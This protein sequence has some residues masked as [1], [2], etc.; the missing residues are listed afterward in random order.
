[1]STYYED[2]RGVKDLDLPWKTLA[3]TNILIVGAT[4]LI[5]R[6]LVDVLMQL[7]H[8]NFHLYAGARD[9]VYAQNCFAEYK[10][11]AAF[12]I[13]S[14]DVVMPMPFDMDFHYII[15]AASYAAPSAFKNDPVGVITAN[16]GGVDHLFSYGIQH[17]L[18]KLLYVSS[19]E[20]Y[21]EGNGTPF[22]EEDS[23]AFDWFSLRACYPLAK[24]TAETLC[25]SYASQYQIETSIVRPCHI[26][27]PFF[28]PKDDRAYAQFIRNVVA[29]ENIVLKSPGLQQRS[30]CY[31]VDCAFAI[32]HVL[33]K[34]E[35]GNAYNIADS[36]ANVSIR[37]FAGMIASKDGLEVVFELP[38]QT[39]E[40]PIIS[41]AF[42]ATEKIKDLGW[43]PQWSLEEGISHTLNTLV[44]T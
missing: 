12:T 27:G 1:M 25:V 5:G 30:W 11:E 38:E 29:G 39:R 28:T 18:R 32:L 43:H 44:E 33:L 17:H 8:R 26:Y 13:L 15:H 35:N 4:G 40:N 14:Y 24:R 34:G 23:G 37:E 36:Q 16:I 10:D 21:G 42:F 31:V 3:E 20:V 19:G 2:I 6:A 22:R 41:Q 7:P 9:L